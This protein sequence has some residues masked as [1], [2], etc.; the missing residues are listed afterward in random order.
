[1]VF[2]T[3]LWLRWCSGTALKVVWQSGSVLPC[4][5][6]SMV[7]RMLFIELSGLYKLCNLNS[8][9]S[10]ALSLCAFPDFTIT[11]PLPRA[12]FVLES[13]EYCQRHY[14]DYIL[15][16]PPLPTYLPLISFP[17]LVGAINAASH[18]SVSGIQFDSHHQLALILPY[19]SFPLFLLCSDHWPCLH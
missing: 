19:P 12:F 6:G 15:I 18:Q 5:G 9:A 17:F 13:C 16:E 14:R 2:F 10:Y 1:V 8:L 4:L 3:S 7:V 11:F